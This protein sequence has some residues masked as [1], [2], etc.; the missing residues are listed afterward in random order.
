MRA[1]PITAVL[2]IVALGCSP[3]PQLRTVRE[4]LTPFVGKN[5]EAAQASLGP[6]T[7]KTTQGAA[8]VYRWTFKSGKLLSSAPAPGDYTTIC[9]IDLIADATNV[10]TG[11]AYGPSPEPCL[12]VVNRL[13]KPR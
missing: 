11:V 13:G 2:A 3:E 10:V 5:V 4:G 9:N 6:P 8:S 7:T 1:A 12:P